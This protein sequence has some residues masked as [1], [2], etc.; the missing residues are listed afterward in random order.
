MSMIFQ[1]YNETGCLLTKNQNIILIEHCT[2][3]R[4]KTQSVLSV[5]SVQ[6]VLTAY[7]SRIITGM[8]YI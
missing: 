6:T 2:L 1:Y 4:E 3:C 7:R 8:I 5:R